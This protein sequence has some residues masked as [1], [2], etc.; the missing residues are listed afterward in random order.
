MDGL[1]IFQI[2][3]LK[4]KNKTLSSFKL[5]P[6]EQTSKQISVSSI[7]NH[8]PLSFPKG[9]RTRRW[10]RY[11]DIKL[12]NLVAAHGLE[13]SI[14]SQQLPGHSIDDIRE[15][16][17]NTL[18]P[19]IRKSLF[20][21]EEDH[22]LLQLVKQHGNNWKEVKRHIKGRSIQ[23]L[24]NRYHSKLKFLNISK[25]RQSPTKL[26][27]RMRRGETYQDHTDIDIISYLGNENEIFVNKNENEDFLQNP[28]C[29]WELE[30]GMACWE[31][32]EPSMNW[33][34]KDPDQG[35][36]CLFASQ[37]KNDFS[38]PANSPGVCLAEFIQSVN[39]RIANLKEL[40]KSNLCKLES[41][42]DFSF[43]SH[44]QSNS[45]TLYEQVCQQQL[46]NLMSETDKSI[47]SFIEEIDY[48]ISIHLDKYICKHEDLFHT[49]IQKLERLKHLVALTSEHCSYI[50]EK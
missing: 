2:Q 13:W 16:Y 37:T 42:G 28:H 38:F 31:D 3:K 18:N 50:I 47:M 26:L 48:E 43:D 35:L 33:T 11:E 36:S 19:E 29:S 15:R 25:F 22:K 10:A 46:S 34:E 8:R 41:Y 17:N 14:I 40:V 20:T 4:I 44:L 12:F 30:I 23:M 27:S 7:E 21:E 9:K 6:T 1:K 45:S 24:K 49:V 39:A 5:A 32:R